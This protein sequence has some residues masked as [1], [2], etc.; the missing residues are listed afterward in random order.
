[1]RWGVAAR[2]AV[3]TQAELDHLLGKLLLPW[4]LLGPPGQEAS[5]SPWV[6]E[7]SLRPLQTDESHC[8]GGRRPP[9]RNRAAS[10]LGTLNLPAD[11][12]LLFS[13]DTPLSAF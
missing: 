6:G 3:L 9:L 4:A 1:M 8:R 12:V 11:H 5:M 7:L 2:G 10:Y 13:G